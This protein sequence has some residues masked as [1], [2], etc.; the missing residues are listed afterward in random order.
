MKDGIIDKPSEATKGG[1]QAIKKIEGILQPIKRVD[2]PEWMTGF[3]GK[4]PSDQARIDLEEAII[5]E[6]EEGEPEPELTGDKFHF[7]LS[8]APKGKEKPNASGFFTRGFTKS[9]VEL[10]AKRRGVSVEDGAMSNLYDT[11][12]ILEKQEVLLGKIKR[13]GQEEKE[14]LYSTNF[15]FVADDDEA[16]GVDMNDHVKTIILG[17][18][19]SAAKRA[20][21]LDNR[22]KRLPEYKE[23]LDGDTL[24][25]LLGIEMVDGKFAEKE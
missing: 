1:F 2:P 6:M 9:A 17:C 5:L 16:S 23:A 11:R 19:K 22:A 7:F 13:E 24:A 8:Y 3:G 12:V 20:I 21:L 15:V 18:T 14:D 4:A 10:D 25:E